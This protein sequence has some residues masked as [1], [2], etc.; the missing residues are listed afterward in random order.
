MQKYLSLFVLLLCTVAL[1]APDTVESLPFRPT[2]DYAFFFAVNDYEQ[3]DDLEN[4]IAN[5]RA[6]AAELKNR[7]GFTTEVVPNPKRKTIREKL[8]ALQRDYEAGRRDP[9]GQLLLY[10]SGHGEFDELLKNGFFVP[11][12]GQPDDLDGTAIQYALWRPFINQ[13]NCK[14]ILVVIDACYSGTFDQ[15]IAMRSS[16]FGRP[17][18]P[19]EREQTLLDH[20]GRKT[21]LYL[22][23]G[24]KVKTP[25]KSDFAKKILAALR[26]GGG[27]DGLLTTG[28]LFELHVKKARPK[29]IQGEFG[30]DEAGSSFLFLEKDTGGAAIDP[31]EESLWQF[32]QT[33]DTPDGYDFYLSSYPNGR[34][35]AEAERK[36]GARPANLPS[37]FVFVKGGTFQMGDTFNEGNDD[38]KPLHSVTLGDFYMSKYEVTF[39]EYDAFCAATKRDKPR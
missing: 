1:L 33:Q 9:E 14:H 31:Q 24:A 22:A 27:A 20:A 28:E 37:D 3:L 8:Q 23:S 30:E 10:F 18:E 39:E 12:D 6:I 38:E 21:R 13:I 7:Y 16:N 26:A 29:P 19:A 15:S 5:A 2:K 32:V 11:A 34:Y 17:G 35:K 4:P 25:D 36:R